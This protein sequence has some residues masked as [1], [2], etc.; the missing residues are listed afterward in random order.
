MP[1]PSKAQPPKK[2]IQKAAL[3]ETEKA[4]QRSLAKIKRLNMKLAKIKAISVNM[5]SLSTRTNE[6]SSR[7]V[8]HWSNQII[9]ILNGDS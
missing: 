8:E 6:I 3:T 7:Q 4:H 2:V 1:T 5:H 9:K